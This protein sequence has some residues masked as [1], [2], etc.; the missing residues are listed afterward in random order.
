MVCAL[1]QPRSAY[2]TTAALSAGVAFPMQSSLGKN[3]PQKVE[4]I[5]PPGA[6]HSKT[7]GKR[8]SSLQYPSMPL[9]SVIGAEGN[10]ADRRSADR[11]RLGGA[12]SNSVTAVS[13][14]T[15]ALSAWNCHL[16]PTPC[17]PGPGLPGIGRPWDGV[18]LVGGV[19]PEKLK[20]PCMGWVGV[21]GI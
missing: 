15:T 1:V 8:S 20:G 11:S 3:L 4:Q 19:G 10:T 12:K 17:A 13:N 2:L 21:Q 18:P 7:F 14:Y 9:E 6:R 5:R 16:L